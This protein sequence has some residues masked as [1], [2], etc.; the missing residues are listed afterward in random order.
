MGKEPL[1]VWIPGKKPK[2]APLIR[3]AKMYQDREIMLN[4]I[5]KLTRTTMQETKKACSGFLDLDLIYELAC[6]N[7][8][9]PE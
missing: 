1:P 8:E 2:L 3:A 6:T 7:G 5:A 9:L 4:R